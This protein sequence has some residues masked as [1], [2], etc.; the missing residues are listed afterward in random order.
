LSRGGRLSRAHASG[1]GAG[2][3]TYLTAANQY[4]GQATPGDADNISTPAYL[5]VNHILKI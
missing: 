2:W 3:V 1:S 5:I 4:D